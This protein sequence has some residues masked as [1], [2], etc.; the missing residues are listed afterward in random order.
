[1]G[2]LFLIL[3]VLAIVFAVTLPGFNIGDLGTANLGF[4]LKDKLLNLLPKSENEIIIEGIGKNY[5]ILDK[6]FSETAA[7]IISSDTLS[8]EQKQ[9]FQQAIEAFQS[10]EE[11][12]SQV[13]SKLD[14]A[15]NKGIIS[16]IVNS[17]FGTNTAT[18]QTPTPEATYIPPQCKL[19]CD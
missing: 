6:F 10:S 8:T 11:Y 3:A 19:V 4:D 2:Y 16:T 12:I 13:E 1:M 14:Q 17:V 7:N 9:E 5:D 15:D 18:Q